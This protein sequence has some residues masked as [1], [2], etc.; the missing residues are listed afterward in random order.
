M[1][2]SSLETIKRRRQGLPPKPVGLNIESYLEEFNE[3]KKVDVESDRC[4]NLN[5]YFKYFFFLHKRLCKNIF[6]LISK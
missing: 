6:N 4:L 2:L 5:S 1:A 3:K